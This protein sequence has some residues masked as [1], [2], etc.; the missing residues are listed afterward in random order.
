VRGN[1]KTGGSKVG[2]LGSANSGEAEHLLLSMMT[3][4]LHH[5]NQLSIVG[6]NLNATQAYYF[7]KVM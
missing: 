1:P 2:S 3:S 4:H 5:L 7:G 6:L